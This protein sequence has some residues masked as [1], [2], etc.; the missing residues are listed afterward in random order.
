[1]IK[2]ISLIKENI[3]KPKAIFLAGPAGSG[4]TTIIKQLIPTTSNFVNLNVDDTYEELLKT[5]GLGMNIKN[6]TSDQ[7]SQA[8]K[9]MGSAQKITKEKYAELS[10]NLKNI[11]IDGTAAAYNPIN[12]KKQELENLGYDTLM[13]MLYVSPLTSLERN[14]NRERSLL[15]QIILRT[16]RDVNENI[17]KYQE[18]FGSNFILIN[19]DPQGAQIKF[20]PEEVKTKFF[21]STPDRK[22]SIPPTPEELEKKRLEIEKLNKEVEMLSTKKRKFNTLSQAKIKINNFIK[23]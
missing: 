9:L 16:W 22:K 4:K 18:L 3:Q 1:V 17:D 10:S 2:L 8:A 6:F 5:S 23:Q 20:N 12:K 11:I 13:L 7:L 19:N 14:F 15:P 21:D